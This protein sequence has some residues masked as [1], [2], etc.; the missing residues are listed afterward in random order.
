MYKKC[1][2]CGYERKGD[3]NA[4]DDQC[5]ACGLIYS[6]WMK[7][8]FAP[9]PEPEPDTF[10][11]AESRLKEIGRTILERVIAPKPYLDPMVVYGQLILL[12]LLIFVGVRFLSYG[13]D[14]HLFQG[15]DARFLHRVNLVFHEAGHVIFR[16]FGE[17][18]FILGGTLMQLIVPMV[19]AIYFLFWREDSFSSSAMLWWFGQNAL[20]IA[21]YVNDARKMELMLLGGGT[22]KEVGGHDWNNLL[23]MTNCLK[24]DNTLAWIFY[25]AG[26][27]LMILAIIWGGYTLLLEHKNRA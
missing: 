24:Y 27:T 11:I 13:V 14:Q 3:E 17:F 18:I 23:R 16:P 15:M 25:S 20:D 7:N 19:F 8:R 6:K 12:I 10:E 26:T 1:P 5:P 22:G 4:P 9:P 21:P 2:E